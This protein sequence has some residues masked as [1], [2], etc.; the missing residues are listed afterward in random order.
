M[1]AFAGHLQVGTPEFLAV[2][3]D[4][5]RTYRKVRL[6]PVVG[7]QLCNQS[8]M[9]GS[10]ETGR[11]PGCN[12]PLEIRKEASMTDRSS[13]LSALREILASCEAEADSLGLEMIGFLLAMALQEIDVQEAS[14][15]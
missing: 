12:V 6:Y 11:T 15:Q 2:C 4:R 13:R 9:L 3:A 5:Y 1:P 8:D 14:N 10:A 7:S